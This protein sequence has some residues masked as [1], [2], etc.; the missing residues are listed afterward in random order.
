VGSVRCQLL[1]R[2]VVQTRMPCCTVRSAQRSA[3]SSEHASFQGIHLP[4]QNRGCRAASL[5][6]RIP[7]YSSAAVFNRLHE[8]AK[9][10][11]SRTK[12]PAQSSGSGSA[13][14]K[15]LAVPLPPANKPFSTAQQQ[16]VELLL[17]KATISA[18]LQ[19]QWVGNLQVQRMLWLLR[20]GV[21]LPSRKALSGSILQRAVKVADADRAKKIAGSSR[22]KRFAAKYVAAECSNVRPLY[23]LLSLLH[24]M[25][26]LYDMSHA[27]AWGP[28]QT[29]RRTCHV[30][31][32][33]VPGVNGA[34]GYREGDLQHPPNRAPVFLCCAP[35][36]SAAG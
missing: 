27:Q 30:Q 23:A 36:A 5:P 22:G 26:I 3:Q 31:R 34:D 14:Q 10:D 17:L 7:A 29:L 20:P 19:L 13:E 2:M 9:R 35:Y 12:A 25:L 8:K 15:L 4:Q 32:R 18:K 6:L 1:L 16:G 24:Q 33:A 28:W 11:M 21:K